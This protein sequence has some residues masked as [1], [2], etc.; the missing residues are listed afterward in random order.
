[1][2]PHQGIVWV[3]KQFSVG[4]LKGTWLP[5][6][7]PYTC[8]Y[9]T[10]TDIVITPE[11]Y[12]FRHMLNEIDQFGSWWYYFM[13]PD[14]MATLKAGQTYRYTFAGP[15]QGYVKHTQTG[16]S[17]TVYWNATDAEGHQIT[18]ITLSEV[19]W[20]SATSYQ[21]V[22]I[23]PSL[24]NNILTLVG[25]TSNEYPLISLYNKYG[26]L[27]NSGYITWSQKPATATVQT[28]VTVSYAEL[29]FISGPYGNPWAKMY[30]TTIVESHR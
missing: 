16:T 6:L 13:A 18:G 24:L 29:D 3:Q 17:V 20:L 26:A 12:V 1:M 19:G 14:Q 30:V 10:P 23:V 15:I 28:G 25:Q 21:P 4:P 8:N 22:P 7:W 2:V 11:P 27:I 5:V 9:T